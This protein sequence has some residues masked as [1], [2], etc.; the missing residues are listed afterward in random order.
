MKKI[1]TTVALAV[2]GVAAI[3]QQDEQFSMNMFNRLAVNPGYAGTSQAL[4]ATGF[5]RQQWNSFPG[6]PKSALVS[7]DYGRI[8]GGGLGVTVNQD[9]LGFEKTLKAKLAYSYHLPIGNA[10]V[11][12]I[13]LDAGMIQKSI[14]GNFLAP[15][16][17]TTAAPGT[18]AAIPWGGAAATTYDLGF[19]LYFAGN[20]GTYVGIS[21]LHIPEQQL[22]EAGSAGP[23]GSSLNW[24]FNYK[25]ARHY[26]IMAGH[27]FN[28]NPQF[29]LTPSVLVKSDASST[30]MDFNLLAKWNNMVFV[31]VSYRLTDAIPIMA[32]LEWGVSPKGTLKVGY[33][34]DVTLSAIKNHSNG[35]HEIMLGYCHKLV[36]EPKPSGHENVRFF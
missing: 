32:G 13:G 25:V 21:A 15:D 6:A 18:D 17:S 3:A 30:Q 9:V 23:S 33:S 7:I 5:Y 31:G 19:G 27:K 34:Y 1:L 26:Y 14:T 8:L 10:G 29:S 4:C 24:S 20:K 11:L 36:S 16:G 35:T 2:I 22:K 28:L 12:G